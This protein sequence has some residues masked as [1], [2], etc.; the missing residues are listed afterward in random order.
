MSGDRVR[1]REQ[2]ATGSDI[3]NHLGACDRNYVPPLSTRVDLDAYS[4]K[5]FSRSSTFEAWHG[6]SLVGLVAAY[7]NDPERNAG[8]ITSVSVMEGFLGEGIASRLL[9]MCLERS[10]QLGMR[11][12]ALEVAAA[13]TTAIQLYRKFGFAASGGDTDPITMSLR[14]REETQR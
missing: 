9:A 5:L 1:Y 12:I 3:R 14:L 4:T 7:L 8:F 10:R 2:A 11:E 13:N 6:N